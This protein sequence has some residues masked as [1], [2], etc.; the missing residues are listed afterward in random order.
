MFGCEGERERERE[1]NRERKSKTKSERER[2][3]ERASARARERIRERECVCFQIVSDRRAPAKVAGGE[4]CLSIDGDQQLLAPTQV[5]AEVLEPCQ[6]A[7]PQLC[8][9]E[10]AVRGRALN[11]H[12]RY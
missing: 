2:A 10:F 6:S 11:T 9:T 3:R 4:R 5:A 7:Q 8:G 12:S 1:R